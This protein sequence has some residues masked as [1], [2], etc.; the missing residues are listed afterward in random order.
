MTDHPAGAGQETQTEDDGHRLETRKSPA[1]HR[2]ARNDEKN[3]PNGITRTG[4]WGARLN[5]EECSWVG[6]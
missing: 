4:L 5:R 6:G 1:N 3:E 2:E